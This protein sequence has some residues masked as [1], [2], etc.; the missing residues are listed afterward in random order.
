MKIKYDIPAPPDGAMERTIELGKLRMRSYKTRSMPISRLIALQLGRFSPLYWAAQLLALFAMLCLE[1]TGKQDTE[2]GLTAMIVY[3][4]AISL[5]ACPELMRGISYK[6][7][8]IEQS[9][10]ISA[11]RLMVSMLLIIAA[12]DLVALVPAAFIAAAKF[13][14]DAAVTLIAGTSLLFLSRFLTLLALRTLS[15][16]K[17][18]AGALSLS[19]VL[20][21]ALAAIYIRLPWSLGLWTAG[22]LVSLALLILEVA[23]ELRR[24]E[25]RK[26][27]CIWSCV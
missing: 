16:I 5:F 15:F 3:A 14:T 23:L 22:A 18:R 19:L 12:V 1:G 9:C 25:N 24:L 27:N 20:S 8:E 21:V 10:R 26:E 7:S 13:E 6:M 2:A 17:S 4:G 11:S